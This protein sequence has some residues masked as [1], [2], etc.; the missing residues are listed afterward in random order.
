MYGIIILY[1]CF[2]I[3]FFRKKYR[4]ISLSVGISHLV[5]TMVLYICLQCFFISTEFFFLVNSVQMYFSIEQILTKHTSLKVYDKR[6][7]LGILLV[8]GVQLIFYSISGNVILCLVLCNIIYSIWGIV[9]YYVLQFRGSEIELSDFSATKTALNVLRGYK[10]TGALE[11]GISVLFVFLETLIMCFM[12]EQLGLMNQKLLIARRIILCMV[13]LAGYFFLFATPTLE[14]L[15]IVY[16][17]FSN[18]NGSLVNIVLD[19][20]NNKDS[21]KRVTNLE[22]NVIKVCSLYK[23]R[24][25]GVLKE[26][27]QPNVI[28]VMNESFADLGVMGGFKTNR[29]VTPFLNNWKAG[30]TKGYVHVSVYGGNTAYSEYEFLTGHTTRFFNQCPYSSKYIKSGDSID[31]VVSL[32]NHLNY[33]TIAMHPYLSSGWRRPIVYKAMGFD[34]QYYLKD[35]SEQELIRRFVSDKSQYRKIY[36]LFEEKRIDDRVFIF[37]VTMQNHGGYADEANMKKTIELSDFPDRFPWTE[38]YLSLIH[39]SDSALKEL[40]TNLEAM[41]EPVVLILFG[42]HQPRIE[43]E[44]IESVYGKKLDA[45]NV[46]ERSKLYMTPYYVWTN[47]REPLKIEDNLSLNYLASTVIEELGIPQTGYYQYLK[48]LKKKYPVITDQVVWAAKKGIENST[49]GNKELQI[50]QDIVYYNSMSDGRKEI[51]GFF[52]GA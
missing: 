7:W 14:K 1:A 43:Q 19:I 28:V 32:M 41:D 47:Y 11:V 48:E 6:Y 8:F 22:D 5:L 18:I 34:E 46:E 39:E 20:R 45:L 52:R 38:N 3:V 21:G 30:V 2:L 50:Y 12:A 26:G 10:I 13:S 35:F 24:E 17:P 4:S 23:N 42:D 36:K 9:D 31:S 49:E 25:G 51:D 40:V 33:R 15:R 27:A 16:D 29:E 37:D 44:F